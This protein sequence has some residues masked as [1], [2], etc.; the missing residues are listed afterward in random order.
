MFMARFDEL[1]QESMHRI[2][3]VET[4][5]AGADKV[6]EDILQRLNLDGPVLGSASD[7]PCCQPLIRA[8]PEG[9]AQFCG[10]FVLMRQPS[11]L[12]VQHPPSRTV[13]AS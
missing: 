13:H 5:M 3:A 9:S 11:W 8:S 7:P 12:R 4:R 2:E 10:R 1:R 6:L